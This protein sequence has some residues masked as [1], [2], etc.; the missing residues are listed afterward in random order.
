MATSIAKERSAARKADTLSVFDC[1]NSY[2]KTVTSVFSSIP[3]GGAF[4]AARDGITTA[5]TDDSDKFRESGFSATPGLGI[6]TR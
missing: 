1:L 5:A 6:T 4:Y 2:G 3:S